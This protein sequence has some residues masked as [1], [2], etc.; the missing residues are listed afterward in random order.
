MER[1]GKAVREAANANLK[2]QYLFRKT[3]L[4]NGEIIAPSIMIMIG[5]SLM[6]YWIYRKVRYDPALTITGSGHKWLEEDWEP[7]VQPLIGAET[8]EK[9]NPINYTYNREEERPQDHIDRL[10]VPKAT[11]LP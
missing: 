5:A 10:H 8:L 7:K 1:F 11:D 2:K 9:H 6:G 4:K 3:Y